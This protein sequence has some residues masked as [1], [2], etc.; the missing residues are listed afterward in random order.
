MLG[1]CEVGV[2]AWDEVAVLRNR[3]VAAKSEVGAF[4]MELVLVPLIEVRDVSLFDNSGEMGTVNVNFEFALIFFGKVPNVIEHP[5]I[6]FRRGGKISHFLGSPAGD[7]VVE[8]DKVR[9]VLLCQFA[10]VVKMLVVY[11]GYGAG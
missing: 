11:G 10:D 4:A 9:V 3:H 5:L 8:P 7:K 1:G 6:L 2:E